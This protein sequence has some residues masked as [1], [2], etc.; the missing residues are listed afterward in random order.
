MNTWGEAMKAIGEL[1]ERVSELEARIPAPEIRTRTRYLD[2]NGAIVDRTAPSPTDDGQIVVSANEW[3]RLVRVD[4]EAREFMRWL[5][6]DAI[7]G[8]TRESSI[9][10]GLREALGR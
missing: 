6:S 2:E 4:N 1:E 10:T 8:L 7:R 9:M 3:E 5:G